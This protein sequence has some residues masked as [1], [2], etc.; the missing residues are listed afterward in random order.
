MAAAGGQQS[1]G[2]CPCFSWGKTS[3]PQKQLWV[4]EQKEW[5][6]GRGSLAAAGRTSARAGRKLNYVYKTVD[7]FP[8]KPFPSA[9]PSLLCIF[10][11]IIS[12]QHRLRGS[13]AY[14]PHHQSSQRR[15]PGAS[16]HSSKVPVQTCHLPATCFGS[17]TW[18][19]LYTSR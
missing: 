8:H 18:L 16:S 11:T 9:F 6:W 14:L 13:S 17:N 3:L 7:K 5:P 15:R 4:E 1:Q 2:W 19:D 12:P 10:C